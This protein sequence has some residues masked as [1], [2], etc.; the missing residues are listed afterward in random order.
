[1]LA[2]LVAGL[3]VWFRRRR[4][5][6]AAVLCVG[7]FALTLLALMMKSHLIMGI[8]HGLPVVGLLSLLAGRGAAAA[9]ELIPRHAWALA[10]TW[11]ALVSTSAILAGPDYLGYFNF[12]VGGRARGHEISIYGED[13]GQ[14]RVELARY[15]KE[16]GLTPLYYNHMTPTRYEEV[17]YLGIP[18]RPLRCRTKPPPGSYAALHALS[19]KTTTKDCWAWRHGLEPIAHINHHIY[20]WRIPESTETPKH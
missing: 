19:F 3:F 2:G 14:D 7:A 9:L 13:W 1:M 10:V 5:P 11:V 15:V 20:I 18:S 4:R 6:H 8:R 12:L 17:R 16:H